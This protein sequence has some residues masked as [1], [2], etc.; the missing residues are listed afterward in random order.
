VT[1]PFHEKLNAFL[2][3]LPST[4]ARIAVTLL[5]VAVTAIAYCIAWDAPDGGWEAWLAFLAAMS[6][7]DALQFGVKRKTDATHVEAQAKARA[8]VAVPKVSE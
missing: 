6:G 2:A 1:L 4:N 7:L 5:C 3:K 8:T